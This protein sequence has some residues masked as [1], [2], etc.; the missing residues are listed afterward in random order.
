MTI[1]HEIP[2]RTALKLG[3]AA[4]AATLPSGGA[5]AQA[6]KTVK[7]AALEPLTGPWARGGQMEV[8]GIRMAVADIN[9]GGGI[10]ALGGAKLEL[11]VLDA[12]DSVEKAT[13]AAKRMVAQNPDLVGG[14]GCWLSSFTLGVTEVTE[15]AEIPWL[16]L[17]YSD[18]IT[19]RGFHYVFQVSPTG[20]Q[21]S[22]EAI[23]VIL[24]VARQAGG[25]APA[26]VA[27]IADNTALAVSFLKPLRPLFE[28]YHLQ[29]V[30]DEMFAPPLSDATVMVQRVRGSRPDLLVLPMTG[31]GDLKLVLDKLNEYHLGADRLPR[32]G[33]SG[34]WGDPEFAKTVGPGI[35]DGCMSVMG[36]WPGKGFEDLNR[37]FV[38][39]TKE[40]WMNQDPY[41]TYMETMVLKEA[42]E[43][44]GVADRRKVAEAIRGFDLHDE[45]LAKYF[46]SRH[47]HFDAKG[48][49]V[50]AQLV[51]IQWQGGMPKPIYPASIA[52]AQPVWPKV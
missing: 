2:R 47:L 29:L 30:A 1:M 16:T 40:P 11:V 41:V 25:K 38:E 48:R 15:R 23:P 13:D 50:D 5:R 35:V 21:Q 4:G 14:I 49:L 9:E 17:C 26:T 43:R 45:G 7:I 52:T 44:A 10:K 12:G 32:L 34:L 20:D 6:P 36:N 22:R 18:V 3:L 51:I 39:R 46:P 33:D 8:N 27:V 28:Q 42:L 37:R 24:N 19:D 31:M